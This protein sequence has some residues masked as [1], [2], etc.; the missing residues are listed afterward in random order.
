VGGFNLPP[1]CS[2]SDIPGNRPE[3]DAAEAFE[4][5]LGEKFPEVG[6]LVD[7]EGAREQRLYETIVQIAEWAF[8]EGSGDGYASG[9][10]DAG[11]AKAEMISKVRNDLQTLL[12]TNDTLWEA[13]IAGT[14]I[15]RVKEML[16][17]QRGAIDNLTGM[18]NQLAND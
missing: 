16:R 10:A 11:C 2:V 12:S 17:D 1:G 14:S 18:I 6:K 9:S 15:T 5:A 13:E 3:D 8:T 7:A 4:L